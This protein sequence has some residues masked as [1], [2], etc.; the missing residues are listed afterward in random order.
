[1]E[2]KKHFKLYKSGKQWVTASIATFAV[3]TGLVL[4]GGVVHA[5]DNHPTTTSASVTNTVNNLKPQN[6]PEQQNNTQ[7][8]N[9]VESPK[10][11]SQDNAVQP[12]KETAVMPNATNKDGAKASI[13]NNAHTDNTIYGNID[14]TTINDKE[15]HVTGWNATNQAINKNESR[16]VIAYDDTT[17]S[18]LGR[19]KI[20]NQIAR[21]DVEKVHK[22]IYNAQNSGFNV[23]ISL[24][25]NKMNNY[26]DAIKIISRYSGVPNGNS[27]YVDF[28][29]QPI[30]FDEN[31]YAYLD[32]F[33]VQNGRL[34]VSGW[35]A[36]NKAIQRPNH[37]L[38]LFDRTV[39]REVAR[40]KVTAGINRS[41]VE[42]VYPQV[43]NANVSGFDATF[44]TIN[45]NPNHEYQILSRYS[46]NG[47]GEG[48]YVTYWFNPQ[49][50]APVNQFN[51]GHLDNF[52][53]SK[54]G[55]VTVSG[56]QAT[57]LS[58]IQNN[59]YIILFDTTANRQI[60]SM[61]V[62][63][64]DRPDV[65][66]VYP[67]ILNANKSGYNVTFNLTQAQIAQLFPNHSYSI[68]SRYSA[69]PNGNGNDKQ[70]TDFWSAPIVLNKTASYIDNISLNG[71]VLNVKGWM[72]SDAS[73]T[74]ANPYI[75][76]LNN[77]KEVTR[78]KLILNDRPDV[79]KVYPDVYNSLT[80]GFDTT[81]KLTN[82]QLN[83]LNG[84]MQILL[85]YSAAADGNPI[86]NGGF[87]DQYSKNYATNGGSF[88]FVKVDNNQV[89]FS[90]WHVSDQATDKPYQWIIVLV[91]GKEVGRQLISS[92]TNGLVSYNR[93]DVYNVNPAISN[94][95]TSGFQGIMTLKDNIKNA[96]VQLVHRFS[97]DGQNGE[98]NRV[99]YWSEVMPVTNTFQKGTDQL[100]RNLVAKP[101]KNQ[102][103]IYNGNTLVKTLGPGTWENMAFAQDSSAINNID[104]Y[105]SYT[106]WYR[107]Y[108]TSQDGKTWY[109]TTAMDWRP[110]LM[111]I[112]PSKDVQ[113]QF[114][115]Y[116]VNNGYENANYGL[117]KSSVASFSK[118][119]NANLLDVTA[120][121]LRYV[122]EQ[123]IAAN[124]GTSKLAND[125]NS[126][127]ATVPEL[128]A[129][130]ELSLQSMPNYR[131]GESGTVD[132]DQVIFINNNSKDP[133]KGNTSYAD[134]NYRL[135][136]RTIN[137]QAGN[138]NSDNSPE[139]LVGND[140]DNSNPV[141]QAENLNWEYFLLNYGKL[142][143]Y[144]PDGNF[145]GFRVDAADNIDADVL[146]QMGQLMND[147]YHTKGNPQN[148]ND[149]LSYNEGYHSGAAQ[150]LNEKGNPQLYMDSGEFYTLEN[151]LGR[152]NNRDNIGNLI[153]NSIVNR[154]ND[155]TENEATP[156]WSFVTNHDQRKNLINRLI[157][158]D[159]PNIPDIMGSAYKVEYANQAWQEFYADQEKTNKQYAQYNVPAQ[160]AILL[161]NKDTVPQVYY[162]DLYNETAQYM[163]EKSIY[164]DAITT[165]M[166]AR[167]QF[168][169]GGQ[170]MTK[171]NNNL[172][173]SVRY[174]KGVV[175]A[176]SNGTDKLS[177]TSG[178]AVLV[179]NN[180]NMAQQTVAINM[181]RVHANQQYRN[182]IDTTE[183]GLTYDAENSENPAILTTDSNGILKV[184]VKG[185][186]NP[187]V[188]GYLG[189]WVPV[190]SGDQDVTTSASDVVADKEKT[191]E[192]NAVLDSHMIYEDFSL[193]Q[194]EPTS[195]ENHAY[196]VIAKNANL[197]NTL[198][199]TDFWMAPAYTPF[200]MSRYN[201]G[202]SMTDRYNLGTTA[203]PTKYGSGEELA[204]TIA[205][206]HKAGLKVQEDIVM[207]Q[208]IGFSGQEAVTVTRTNNRGMQIHVN[209][210]TYAN[211][212]YFAYTTGGGNGQETYGG[213]YLAELQK[214][215]PDLFTTKAIST[216]V[217]PDPT[218]R[219]N[220]W[221]AKY[222]NGTSLQN[223][224][225]GLAV[226][227]ANGDYAYLNSG[228]NKTFNTL[229]PS[230][231]SL[232]FN[233]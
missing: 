35:N 62:T 105:L 167:K 126:F 221:S 18:E 100:M 215:Y 27:D 212:I 143:G 128:S 137:N 75:I 14:S 10:K 169:S 208:M 210:Q 151:V 80:S 1:M 8:S 42:K 214:N 180:S 176:N 52:D 81:I 57:N 38:I 202:Y 72:A 29:S 98:G 162:G 20:T 192:S 41:D 79:A 194:P 225:I 82:S 64:V 198:G 71:D 66:K 211:Q 123:S 103:K 219:I 36:T 129:S 115:K 184:T 204:N 74:Q 96:N 16:Y 78:Q 163:Q 59:R 156:N 53:I 50:I 94:S 47:D 199:I 69:D 188:S 173:A 89:A 130:S 88:D 63:S 218:V 209:G 125:I 197:F 19:T 217:A 168:V 73:A 30:I 158:K 28:V 150:M 179:G 228:D 54:A 45:L 145:D 5:A 155:T 68:V 124:K 133:R 118:D 164:Y 95:S 141:V 102:L 161:S 166:R 110:L 33:S 159:H 104:G 55:K 220:K 136:N 7:E 138:N 15:L 139:L 227:L 31:N 60:A 213:K 154:Q 195:V 196:N 117:T 39:N 229:L 9:T 160:Y 90:G 231:I 77:G 200:G 113:A 37:F 121:N 61:K 25:F 134:S 152:A 112:W 23:N 101:N 224:G 170:T 127:A 11:D 216:G 182:L 99:D 233:D 131:P 56:W 51:N 91:N 92:T 232:N 49:R 205:A 114:I 206:L 172:L 76:I 97:D 226:K 177:R 140:I 84:N 144:N 165:L 44:D 43:V 181:G 153:T 116:F 201:E 183:N 147:M 190:I 65:A 87:T 108:G 109:E 178:M 3:S 83:A 175:D 21:P 67:Q 34:H 203:N 22:D 185:Y 171:L 26:R 4:G 17:N 111:Y 223:M 107:P 222:E 122:I 12:L 132:S 148:A 13:T 48:D 120:Q 70:H 32:D 135:M 85:R 106:G 46:N 58:N 2:I 6:D 191:F 207:N 40:Q 93:P 189:V 119:T 149:H 186:S 142:M 230:A 174:G 24:D 146:D 157:I 187:Y 193:F 86:N